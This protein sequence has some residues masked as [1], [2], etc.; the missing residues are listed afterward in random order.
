MP[1]ETSLTK[2]QVANQEHK[3]YDPSCYH[4]LWNENYTECDIYSTSWGSESSYAK[5]QSDTTKDP[6]PE[7]IPF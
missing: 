3:N 5:Y 2:E 4:F 1:Y 6:E 7:E